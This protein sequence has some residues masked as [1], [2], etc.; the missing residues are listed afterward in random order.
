MIRM[1]FGKHKG[2]L[3]SNLPDEYLEWL[4][5][6]GDLKPETRRAVE[7]ELASRAPEPGSLLDVVNAGYRSLAMKYHPDHGGKHEQMQAL[8]ASVEAL[9]KMILEIGCPR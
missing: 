2:Q 5:T 4:M 6:L 8:N 3:F 9:R 1:P 7:F